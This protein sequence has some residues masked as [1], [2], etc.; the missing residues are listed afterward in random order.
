MVVDFFG[1]AALRVQRRRDTGGASV[2]SQ[3]RS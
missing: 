2:F 1:F 3:I